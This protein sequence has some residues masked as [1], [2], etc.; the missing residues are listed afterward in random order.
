MWEKR[1]VSQQERK[2][3]LKNFG[4]ISKNY[5]KYSREINKNKN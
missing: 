2:I 5:Q 3:F 4:K 1:K